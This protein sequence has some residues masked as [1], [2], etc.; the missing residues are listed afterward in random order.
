MKLEDIESAIH[1]EHASDQICAP[2]HVKGK[3]ARERPVALTVEDLLKLQVPERKMLIETL[4]PTPGAVLLVGAHK[5]GKTVL[6]AQIAIAEASGH[7]LMDNYRVID[8]GAV[9]V[10]EQDDPAGDVSMRDYLRA[11]P[12]PVAGLPFHLFTRIKYRFGP[13]FYSW[14]ESE[15]EGREAR[16]VILDSYTALR[17]HRRS[18][19]DIV[20]VESDELT[21][22]DALGKRHKCTIMVL[23]HVSKGS[24]GMDW[25]DQTA[26]SFSI[27]AAVEGQIHISRFKD[28]PASAPERLLQGRGRHLEDFQ[29]VIRFR[30]PT[31]DYEIVL[32]GSGAP[33]FM[34]ILE[35]KTNFQ[36]RVF[37][38]KDLY[39]ELGMSRSS[40]F[41]LTVRL[42]SAGV[43]RRQ[44]YGEYQLSAEVL[45]QLGGVK[46]GTPE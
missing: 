37:S 16:L 45:C 24:F 29:S 1:A 31:L 44:G 22:I 21:L 40:A 27:G 5:S 34:E 9:I 30:K 10:V 13:D 28:L 46:S 39:Q 38:Q 3:A 17:P 6:S 35:I 2:A 14:L 7:P 42:S 36:D 26:G 23:H 43:L 19:G 8:Q 25:S 41:R 33:L 12:I 20:K 15:I 11:S 18:G 32:E 4:I